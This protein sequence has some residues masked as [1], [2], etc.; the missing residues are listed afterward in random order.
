MTGGQK[1]SHTLGW[2]LNCVSGN[3]W[4]LNCV[5]GNMRIDAIFKSNLSLYFC[6]QVVTFIM[7]TIDSGMDKARISI[8]KLPL[9]QLN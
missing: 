1:I 4:I 8:G 2:P 3:M 6:I 9:T 5:S 7:H